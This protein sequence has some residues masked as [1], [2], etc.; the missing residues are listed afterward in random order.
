MKS[1]TRLI[2]GGGVTPYAYL[3]PAL[4]IFILFVFTPVV[5]SMT[6]SMY[7]FTG[8]DSR[9]FN[10]FVGIKNYRTLFA[11]KYFLIS[12]RNTVYFVLASISI[13]VAVALFLAILIFVGRFASPHSSARSSSSPVYSP[14][15]PS[16]SPGGECWSRTGSSTGFSAASTSP[17]CP[18]FSLPSGASSS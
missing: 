11:D 13:Q 7:Q 1:D 2:G 18:A 10:K 16:A 4:L 9:L 5:F 8:F 6:L 15:F 3:A 12:I 14:R 17:G